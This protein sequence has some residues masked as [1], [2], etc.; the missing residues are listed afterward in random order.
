MFL[1]FFFRSAGSGF[2]SSRALLARARCSLGKVAIWGPNAKKTKDEK[3]WI[4]TY[5][6][7][8]IYMYNYLISEN[9]DE[10][11]RR[12]MG[13]KSWRHHNQQKPGLHLQ[14]CGHHLCKIFENVM[15]SDHQTWLAGKYSM[16]ISHTVD[17]C[18]WTFQ[19]E[20]VPQIGVKGLVSSGRVARIQPTMIF[21]GKAMVSG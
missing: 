16:E 1:T 21:T 2:W 11:R 6:Y 12:R 20:I 15:L 4:H 17:V 3:A 19:W 13:I 10:R 14:R 7:T 8:Y 9:G 5:M 18:K